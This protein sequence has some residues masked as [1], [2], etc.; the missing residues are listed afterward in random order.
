[1][2]GVGLAL[3][4]VRERQR[5]ARARIVDL[6]VRAF[7]AAARRVHELRRAGARLFRQKTNTE[8]FAARLEQRVLRVGILTEQPRI[9][10]AR[11]ERAVW[12]FAARERA[13]PTALRSR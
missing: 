10:R 4:V 9:T 7:A 2:N 12:I 11:L 5:F 13:V 3:H 1:M 8:L 6:D